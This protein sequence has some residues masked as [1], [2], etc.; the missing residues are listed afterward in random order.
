MSKQAPPPPYYQPN[1]PAPIPQ[2]HVMSN[3]GP[4]PQR[5]VCPSCHAEVLTSMKTQ[6]TTKTHLMALLLCLFM[7][8]PCVCVPYCM[9]SCQNRNHYC[10]NC[11]A[12]LGKYE[13]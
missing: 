6:A 11:Q 7:C 9:D 1:A 13:S 2:V 12:Y 10:P 5:C 8:I 4:D 3:F